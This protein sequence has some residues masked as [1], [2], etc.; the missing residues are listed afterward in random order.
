MHLRTQ[1]TLSGVTLSIIHPHSIIS[2][3]C[4]QTLHMFWQD[5]LHVACCEKFL[6]KEFCLCHEVLKKSFYDWSRFFASQD[7]HG[8]GLLGQ[9]FLN[10][11]VSLCF[12]LASNDA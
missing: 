9:R 5:G 4:R 7:N 1:M 11:L 2:A 3:S 10:M 12:M 6:L 8:A